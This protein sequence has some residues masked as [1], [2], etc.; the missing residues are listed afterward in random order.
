[1]G[2][3]AL[4]LKVYFMVWLIHSLVNPTLAAANV[5]VMTAL[6]LGLIHGFAQSPG[7]FSAMRPPAL[8][9]KSKTN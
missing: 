5:D 9:S 2:P 3:L 8:F 7:L 4:I 1:M 6:T